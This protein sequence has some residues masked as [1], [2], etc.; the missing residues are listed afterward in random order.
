MRA[1]QMVFQIILLLCSLYAISVKAAGLAI[2]SSCQA[3]C[4]N[5]SI[6]YPFGIGAGCYADNWFEVV[7]GND[8]LGASPKPFL[9]SFSLE[10]LNISLRGTVRVNYPISFNCSDGNT[11]SIPSVDFA[12]SPFIFSQSD[13]RFTAIGCNTFASMV[14]L[15]GSNTLGGCLSICDATYKVVNASSCNGINCCQTTI[16]SHLVAF[17]ATIE[18]VDSLNCRLGNCPRQRSF[19]IQDCKYAFLVEETWF[20]KH[21]SDNI[22]FREVPVALEWGLPYTSI[23]NNTSSN[24]NCTEFLV[25]NANRNATTFTCS[26]EKG[27]EGNPYLLGGCHGKVFVPL[28]LSFSFII[29]FFSFSFLL[30]I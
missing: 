30:C 1:V 20:Q 2:N 22:T 16:P 26:C 12:K 29:F 17:N 28:P 21:G 23:A 3:S 15:D 14:S 24:S 18:A 8:S 13:N 4:G 11:S 7:C 25:S 10:V 19:N 5:V 9:R 6:P 27:F